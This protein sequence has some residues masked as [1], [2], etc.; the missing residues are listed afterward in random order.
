MI[1][2]LTSIR[3]L[4]QR[5]LRILINSSLAEGCLPFPFLYTDIHS[6]YFQE[7]FSEFIPLLVCRNICLRY[8][9]TNVSYLAGGNTVEDVNTTLSLLGC[10]V[11]AAIQIVD[12]QGR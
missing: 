8:A 1:F 4:D 10:F 3:D 5:Y 2:V 9:R 6:S 12:L 7:S 11:N